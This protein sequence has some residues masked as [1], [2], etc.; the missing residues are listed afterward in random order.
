MNQMYV[1]PLDIDHAKI[2]FKYLDEECLYT[3]IPDKKFSTIAELEARFKRLISGSDD[4]DQT[5]LNWV[6]FNNAEMNQPIGRLQVTIF[7][8]QQLAQIGY[9]IFKEYWGFGYATQSVLWMEQHIKSFYNIVRIEAY[10]DPNNIA[11]SKVLLKNDFKLISQN[12]D[13]LYYLKELI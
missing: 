12:E 9:V 3:Y 13:D 1:A 7:K 5:W 4:E 10:V 8:E 11:S 2:L 6:M